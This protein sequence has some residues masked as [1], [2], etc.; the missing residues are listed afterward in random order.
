LIRHG[1]FAMQINNY[2]PAS[3]VKPFEGSPNEI[4][5]RLIGDI[6]NSCDSEEQRSQSLK[7]E[8]NEVESSVKRI[9]AVVIEECGVALEQLL[10]FLGE[11]QQ[12]N[13]VGIATE[14]LAG[15]ELCDK[16]C[17]DAVFL[18]INLS[19]E[20]GIL[21]A[22]RLAALQDPPRLVLTA[23]SSERATYA[24]RLGAVHYLMKPLDRLQVSEAI[25]RLLGQL[26]PI[27]FGSL[28]GFPNLVLPLDTVVFNEASHELLPVTSV[29]HDQIR[30]LAR[31]EIVAVLRGKRRTW[32]HTVLEEFP[33]YYQLAQLMRR[34]KGEPFVQVGRHAIVN[35]R[36]IQ[37]VWQ[38]SGRRYRLR[39]HDRVGT[40]VNAS[41]SGSGRLLAAFKARTG[42]QTGAVPVSRSSVPA[43]H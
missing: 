17:P 1:E 23:T 42:S 11:F 32:V 20:A 30:L 15:L 9:R 13:I 22:T 38:Q 28:A 26:H 12:V 21:L 43:R 39:L 41:R 33:T 10:N 14:C 19:D 8:V 2:N 6:A 18:D 7:S 35:L 16:L 36:G 5:Q 34:L 27:E 24:F 4:I 31:H 37:Q 40:V 25:D 3:E 29:D